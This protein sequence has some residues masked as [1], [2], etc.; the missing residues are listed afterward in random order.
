MTTINRYLTHTV[1]IGT[2][3]MAAGVRTVVDVENVPAFIT[4]RDGVTRSGS[5]TF[6][7]TETVI[8]L[9][10]DQSI[11]FDD[12]ITFDGNTFPVVDIY[13]ARDEVGVHHLEVLLG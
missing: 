13:K 7:K 3:T 2:V 9:K 6:I 8:F 11:S 1:T 5:G 10:P 4:N 12:Q